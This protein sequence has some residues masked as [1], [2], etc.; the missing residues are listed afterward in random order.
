MIT[1]LFDL[2]RTLRKASERLA[3]GRR[4][5]RA[6][7]DFAEDPPNPLA[8]FRSAL[9]KETFVEVE[10]VPDPMLVQ[11]LRAHL[12]KLILARV[13]WDDE[14]RI[15]RAWNEAAIELDDS[16]RLPRLPKGAIPDGQG[17]G[18][19]SPRTLLLAALV[20]ADDARR[21][22]VA[23]AL[24][25]GVAE[26]VR[27]AVRIH[28]ERRARAAATLGVT[29]D[30]IELPAPAAAIEGAVAEVLAVTDPIAERI[31]PWDRGLARLAARD[32]VSGWPAHLSPRWILSIFEGTE[33]TRGLALRDVRL[34]AILGASSFA[35]AL[36][37]FGEALGE[38]AAPSGAPF[39]IARPALDLR[40]LRLGALL[41]L[42]AGEETFARRTLSLGAGAARDHVRTMAGAACVHTRLLAAA[43]R[44]RAA[45]FPPAADLDDRSCEATARAWGEPLPPAL[46]GAL[47]RVD[48]E[49]PSRFTAL[50]LAAL[51]RKRL[52]EELD[53]DWYR[54]PRSAEALLALA[55]E[56]A[57]PVT[58]ELLRAGASELGRSLART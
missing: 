19:V 29:L 22:G 7:F 25:R 9:M 26:R 48:E 38:A 27:D 4:A 32:A 45:M 35:R 14:A 51:D 8:P 53:E 13:L 40:P 21:R 44:T 18:R 52:V 41:Y 20:D 11:P 28:A 49:T 3:R 30:A 54:N 34:P 58:E 2:D 36:A 12:A 5:L 23:D 24:A 31:A 43:M 10:G 17:S 46:A 55:A 42:L 57:P 6:T 50:L 16:V 15:A 39:A 33:L 37:L 47:P 56:P 1:S